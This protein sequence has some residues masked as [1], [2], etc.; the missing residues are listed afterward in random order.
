MNPLSQSQT[1]QKWWGTVQKGLGGRQDSPSGGKKRRR[2]RNANRNERS[3]GRSLL[4]DH[5]KWTFSTSKLGSWWRLAVGGWS[6]G[7]VR[8]KK[9]LRS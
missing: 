5:M 2:V 9:N 1:A 4:H 8:N 3:R 7:A 6:R